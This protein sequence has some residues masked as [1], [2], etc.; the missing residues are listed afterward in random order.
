M[1]NRTTGS[2]ADMFIYVLNRATGS[3]NELF[4]TLSAH[5][6]IAS[7]ILSVE[8]VRGLGH[9]QVFGCFSTGLRSSRHRLYLLNWEAVLVGE[10]CEKHEMFI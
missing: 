3:L 1:L 2:L 6:P 4:S 7:I 5:F 8:D 10:V 9:V